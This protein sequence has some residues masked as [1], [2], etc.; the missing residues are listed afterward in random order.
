MGIDRRS[1]IGVGAAAAA[2]AAS[3]AMAKAAK[4]AKAVNPAFPKGFLWGAATSGHQI[5][6]NNVNADTWLAENVKPTAYAE[7][8]GDACN[9]FELWPQ[10]LDLVKAMGLNTYRFSLEW[11]RIEPEPGRFSIAMLDHYKAIIAG[12]HQRGLTPMLTFNHYTT[13]RWFAARGG[14]TAADAPDLFGRFC[15]RAARHLAD[16]L[17]YATTL[18]EPNL[19][20]VI[21]AAIPPEQLAKLLPLFKASAE[22][23]ARAMGS[24]VFVSGNSIAYDDLDALTARQIAGHRTGRAAIKAVRGDLPV[25]VSL[26]IPD[27]QP[28]GKNSIRDVMRDKQHKAWLEAARGDD[29]LGVQNYER[30]LWDD[31]GKVEPKSSGDHNLAGAPIFPDSIANAVRYAYSV[32]KVPIIVTEHGVNTDDD[33][34]RARFTLAALG[35]LKKTIDEGVPVKGYLHWSLLDNFEWIFGYKMKYGLVAVDRTTFKRTPKPSS[36]IYGA[37]ARNNSL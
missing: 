17:A 25:G 26:A 4:A 1:L 36:S 11:S 33:A 23:Q 13:P 2:A 34:L 24:K 15:D 19:P 3:P 12:C 9:S 14:W 35:E 29:F 16:G 8:S 30:S 22:A 21:R 27:D 20:Q 6:G 10:D 31:K 32:A 37:V 18:N 5:E 7:P 28:L